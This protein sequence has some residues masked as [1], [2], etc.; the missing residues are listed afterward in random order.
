[1]GANCSWLGSAVTYV[2]TPG[3]RLIAF[4]T[5]TMKRTELSCVLGSSIG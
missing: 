2:R 5:P 3:T 4:S 1:M